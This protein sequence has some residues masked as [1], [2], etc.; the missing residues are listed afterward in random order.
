MPHSRVS[1]V[2]RIPL[3]DDLTSAQ[4]PPGSNILVE[5]DPSSHWYAASISIAAGWLK[6]G[7]SVSYNTLAQPPSNVRNA[8]KR[9]GVDPAPLEAEPTPPN[10]RLRIWDWYTQTLG[11]KSTE[12]LISPLKAADLSIMFSRE[13][14][15]LKPDP[16][17]LRITDDWSTFAR[18]NDEKTMVEFTLTRAHPLA[19]MIKAT[20][21]AGLMKGVHSDWVYSRLE[22]ANDGIVDVKVEELGGE[23]KNLLRIRTMRNV[24]FD[25]RWHVLKIDGNFD[26]T[27]ER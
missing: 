20:G 8:L 15:K 18:F 14:F 23:I 17:R 1:T 16:L 26:V 13:Q 19:T 2:A 5:Y 10:E 24:S 27:I 25:S 11:M 6:Q 4:V 7:G 12:K 3:I 9:I 21:I 22:A